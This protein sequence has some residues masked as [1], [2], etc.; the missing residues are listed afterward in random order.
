MI[1]V[2]SGHLHKQSFDP[3]TFKFSEKGQTKFPPIILGKQPRAPADVESGDSS[4]DDTEESEESS[5]LEEEE[6]SIIGKSNEK[7]KKY[8]R[9]SKRSNCSIHACDSSSG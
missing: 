3:N 1:C 8:K 9:K 5:S 4:K 6:Y 7:R 2:I